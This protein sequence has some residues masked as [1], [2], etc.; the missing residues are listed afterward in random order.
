MY[1]Y[2]ALVSDLSPSQSAVL[3]LL[4]L[5]VHC[6]TPEELLLH[7][8]LHRVASLEDATLGSD[9]ATSSDRLAWSIPDHFASLPKP[10]RPKSLRLHL[11]RQIS[12]RICC[13]PSHHILNG[14][15]SHRATQSQ[16][17]NA[18]QNA[19]GFEPRLQHIFFSVILCL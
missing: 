19:S 15:R 6:S 2:H 16:G 4:S 14:R 17:V 13:N 10:N 8:L 12:V 1:L 3:Q 11:L 5:A 7:Y 18:G 9:C